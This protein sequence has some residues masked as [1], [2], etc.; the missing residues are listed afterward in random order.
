[1]IA[2]G[3]FADVVRSERRARP[4]A[5]APGARV[6]RVTTTRGPAQDVDLAADLELA[7][8]LVRTAGKLAASMRW[9][10]VDVTAKTSISDLVTRADH[11]AEA[12]I[13]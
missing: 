3:L 9:Q 10:G 6:S 8:D 4:R 5:A 2:W 11:A 12:Q 13:A 7:A 1:M